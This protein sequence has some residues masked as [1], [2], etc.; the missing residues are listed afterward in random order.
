MCMK[1]ETHLVSYMVSSSGGCNRN[2]MLQLVHIWK[3]MHH[4]TTTIGFAHAP[5]TAE[6]GQV[7]GQGNALCLR[8]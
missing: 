1:Y 8:P 4:I 6:H 5:H 3:T 2:Y 7:Y